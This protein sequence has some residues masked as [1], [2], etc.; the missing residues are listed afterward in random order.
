V[1]RSYLEGADGGTDFAGSSLHCDAALIERGDT[2]VSLNESEDPG[3]PSTL[4]SC[5]QSDNLSVLAD[6]YAGVRFA[7]D[8]YMNSSWRLKAIKGIGEDGGPKA[9]T[10]A[11]RTGRRTI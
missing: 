11:H 1:W 9:P 5:N 3:D 8:K 10:D 7:V 4:P 2:V 6:K